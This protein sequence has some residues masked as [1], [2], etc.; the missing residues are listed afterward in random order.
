VAGQIGTGIAVEV[1]AVKE[2]G[3]V[4]VRL[5]EADERARVEFTSTERRTHREVNEGV[6][7]LIQRTKNLLTEPPP[8]V[9]PQ[10]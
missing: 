2:T 6:L 4:D 3:G 10:T 1:G 5:A 8:K 9:R 7:R